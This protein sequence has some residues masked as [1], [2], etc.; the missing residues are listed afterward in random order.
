MAD[1]EKAIL[2]WGVIILAWKLFNPPSAVDDAIKTKV[3]TAFDIVEDG[4]LAETDIHS[5]L[6]AMRDPQP[7]QINLI[8]E[9]LSKFVGRSAPKLQV[10]EGGSITDAILSSINIGDPDW[11]SIEDIVKLDLLQYQEKYISV[12]SSIIFARVVRQ[13][14]AHFYPK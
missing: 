5:V 7:P 10:L 14:K 12:S 13:I 4:Y 3:R 11:C 9:E 6:E 8:L 1:F 2:S